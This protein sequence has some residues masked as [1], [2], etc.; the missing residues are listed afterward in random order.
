MSDDL[1]KRI[2][3]LE[4]IAGDQKLKHVYMNYC[5]LGYP[6]TSSDGFSSTTRS[7]P[8]GI[9]VTMW[10]APHS[11]PSSAESPRRS[12]LRPISP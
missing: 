7:G 8:V 5:D 4:S 6:R 11:K 2:D 1:A 9:S 12:F 3:R 10:A